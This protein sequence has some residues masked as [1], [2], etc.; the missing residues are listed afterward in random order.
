MGGRDKGA[1]ML[2]DKS[3]AEIALDKLQQD[4]RKLVVAA[5]RRPAWLGERRHI[6]FASDQVD[7]DGEPV[8]PVGGLLAALLWAHDQAGRDAQVFTLPVDAPFTPSDLCEQLAAAIGDAPGAV[9]HHGERL[10]SIFGVWR[11]SC[12]MDMY[13]LVMDHGARA[14]KDVVRHL[15]ARIVAVEGPADSFTNV[16]TPEDLEAAQTRFES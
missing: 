13:D 9:A 11:A 14:L 3:L 4:A 10:Q 5:P 1:L 16:N 6:A 12:A 7:L 2:G 8:G 15:D